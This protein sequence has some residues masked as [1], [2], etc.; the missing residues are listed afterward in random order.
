MASRGP[1]P[2]PPRSPPTPVATPTPPPS[3]LETSLLSHGDLSHFTTDFFQNVPGL[4]APPVDLA[5]LDF[6]TLPMP[7]WAHMSTDLTAEEQAEVDEDPFADYDDNDTSAIDY[8]ADSNDLVSVEEDELEDSPGPVHESPVPQPLRRRKRALKEQL[9]GGYPC[10]EATP[11]INP[12]ATRLRTHIVPTHCAGENTQAHKRHRR[13]VNMSGDQQ[14]ERRV[15]SVGN[16]DWAGF[17]SMNAPP[18]PP[19]PQPPQPS[20]TFITTSAGPSA[21]FA[22]PLGPLASFAPPPGPSAGFAPPSATTF[23]FSLPPAGPSMAPLLSFPPPEPPS[24]PPQRPP[25]RPQP[26]LAHRRARMEAGETLSNMLVAQADKPTSRWAM[27]DEPGAQPVVQ[28]RAEATP[29]SDPRAPSAEYQPPPPRYRP[30]PPLPPPHSAFYQPISLPPPPAR[31]DAGI[32]RPI[33][34]VSRP[35][36]PVVEDLESGAPSIPSPVASDYNEDALAKDIGGRPTKEQAAKLLQ[37]VQ[38]VRKLALAFG[39]SANLHSDRFINAVACSIPKKG[40]RSGNGWNKYE[41]FARDEQHAVAEY[42]QINPSFDPK[43]MALPQLSNADVNAMW[44]KFQE[45]YPDSKAELILEKYAECVLL[46]GEET[47]ASRQRHFDRICNG[48]RASIDIANE[49]DFEAI[50]LIVGASIHEDTELARVIATP[51]LETAFAKSLT[52]GTTGLPLLNDHLLGVTK[53]CAYAGQLERSM[54]SVL[55]LPE[56][57]EA[58]EALETNIM[59]DAEKLAKAATATTAIAKASME[60]TKGSVVVAKASTELAKGSMEVA[61]ASA[62]VAKVKKASPATLRPV[63][64]STTS[65]VTPTAGPSTITP[66]AGPSIGD[67]VACIG[68]HWE[69]LWRKIIRASSGTQPTRASLQGSS[70]KGSRA[71]RAQE[72]TWFNVA[73]VEHKSDSGWGLRLEHHTYSDGDLVIIGHDYTFAAPQDPSATRE[74]WQTSRG[75]HVPCQDAEGNVWSACIDV[76]RAGDAG[77]TKVFVKAKATKSKKKATVKT[78]EGDDDD[79]DVDEEDGETEEEVISSK[80][81]GKSKAVEGRSK[82]AKVAKV[83]EVRTKS[84]GA[85]KATAVAAK[86]TIAPAKKTAS[87]KRKAPSADS[88]DFYDDDVLEEEEATSPPPAKKLRSAGPITPMPPPPPRTVQRTEPVP[89]PATKPGGKLKPAMKQVSFTPPGAP[90][91]DP[92]VVAERRRCMHAIEP[93]EQDN[94][95]SGSHAEASREAAKAAGQNFSLPQNPVAAPLPS[96]PRA[97]R[98]KPTATPSGPRPPA[99]PAT[100]AQPPAQPANVAQMANQIAGQLAQMPP[101]QLAAFFNMFQPLQQH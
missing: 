65:T 49:N 4:E 57:L 90:A 5:A 39:Q 10:R 98:P 38:V 59:L 21:G 2:N 69:P 77:I 87:G 80:A 100:V 55:M 78:E 97:Q 7:A 37:F 63:R 89:V 96:E 95:P 72:L 30:P 20:S 64:A 33:P 44:R 51:S 41:A 46:G 86:K 16:M 47:L 13:Q 56:A 82:V 48:L 93:V 92:A 27:S 22:P 62:P 88:S 6:S 84:V 50:V 45:A 12:P 43:T 52:N 53:L 36:T 61:K 60:L 26:K 73:L 35:L 67:P 11:P 24:T 40:T 29:T 66:T 71:W 23:S 28:A 75:K 32:H 8:E 91:N 58:L 19:P 3:S 76:R 70:D 79:E 54:G 68:Y 31:Y 83:A 74:Y 81:K 9:G 42:K 101:E 1:N 14:R 94:G 17:K 34:A 25:Q 18:P 99:Q 15:E 85:K